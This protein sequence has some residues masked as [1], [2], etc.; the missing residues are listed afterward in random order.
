[1]RILYHHR[2]QG[3]GVEAVHISGVCSGLRE[4]GCDVEI[5]GP[6]AVSV[7]PDHVVSAESGMTGTVWGKIARRVPQFAFEIMEIA[8]NACAVPRLWGKCRTARPEFIYE[9]YALYN[10]SG[11]MVGRLTRTP[12]VLEVNET[13]DV[14]RTRQGKSLKMPFLA[15][16]FERLI[17]RNAHSVVAVSGYLRDKVIA[18]GAHSDRVHVTPNAVDARWLETTSASGDT[19]RD[20]HKLHGKTVVGFAGSFT[21]WH[22]VDLLISA[23][24]VLLDEFPRLHLLLVGDGAL[25][26]QTEALVQELGISDRV[27]FAGKVPYADMPNYIAA[28]DIGVMPESNTFGSPMKVFEY[29]AV[30]CTPVAPRYG[31]LE[32]VIVDGQTGLLFTPRDEVSLTA[33]LR[34]LLE[35]PDYRRSLGAAAR[36]KV[37]AHHLWRS[38]ARVILD[39][40]QTKAPGPGKPVS[41]GV[42]EA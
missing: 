17:F 19:V 35:T 39:A 8:Y 15:R 10:M 9:R 26:A 33:C 12:V 13:V 42:Q 2:T 21:K 11:I 30:G 34:A 36:E 41:V 20:R 14:D 25:R 16:W 27:T 28:S 29:M 5:L 37:I 24:T 6:P 18:A 3:R 40:L 22:R 7:D 31:P 38:N 32:E 4:L 1:M 23:S